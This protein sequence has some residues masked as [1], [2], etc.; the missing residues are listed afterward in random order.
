MDG[1]VVQL[2]RRALHVSR[3]SLLAFRKVLAHDKIHSHRSVVTIYRAKGGD[4]SR[5]NI[6]PAL[7]YPGDPGWL[8]DCK[9]SMGGVPSILLCLWCKGGCSTATVAAALTF[10]PPNPPCYK[11]RPFGRARTHTAGRSTGSSTSLREARQ[12]PSTL[13]I[14]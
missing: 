1:L 3:S 14:M 2:P 10:F 7:C 4:W 8:C 6:S 9:P 5:G 12:G 11:V 13:R